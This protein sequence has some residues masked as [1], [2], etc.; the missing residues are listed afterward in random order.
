[1]RIIL[2]LF[3]IGIY[4][5]IFSQSTIQKDTS[6]TVFSTYKKEIKK[7]PFI[8]IV[9]KKEAKNVVN[10]KEIIYKKI[11]SRLLHL[12]AFWLK[13]KKQN[14]AVIL[15][16]GGG[17]KSGDKSQMEPLALTIAA[18]GYSCFAIEYRLSPEAKYPA[19]IYDVKNAIQ[20]IK[21]NAKRFH[22]DTTK[23]AV[24]GCSSGGQMAA[25]IG[26]TNGDNRFEENLSNSKAT[27]HVQ[28]IID[29]DGILAF[30]HPESQEGI[31]A[32]QWLGGD[33]ES[34]PSVWKEAAALSHIN[35]NTP[36][37]LFIN[38]DMPRFHAGRT[39]MIAMMDQF[40]IYNEIKTIPN[41]PHSFW[42]FDPWFDEMATWTIAFLDKI[43]K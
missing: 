33:Y 9:R 26:A 21:T 6:Y 40:G 39:D 20:F 2:F 24:L 37:T 34:A 5:P 23:V 12:D 25:L 15:I 18:K 11:D 43:F 42:F 32:S 14:P 41:S 38:S 30:K 22:I 35:K 4:F 8:Q 3:F 36:P 17:W 29:L 1:M 19:A 13:S 16:H 28:A 7:Y 27:T 31:V 10:E